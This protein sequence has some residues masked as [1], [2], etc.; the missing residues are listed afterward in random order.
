MLY[1]IIDDNDEKS[2]YF[3]NTKCIEFGCGCNYYVLKAD[4]PYLKVTTNSGYFNDAIIFND[5]ICI[6]LY[7]DGLR[8]VNL[9]DFSIKNL[10]IDGYFG[11]FYINNDELYVLGCCNVTALDKDINIKWKSPNIAVDG[12]LFNDVINDIMHIQC[13]MDPPGGWVERQIDLRTGSVVR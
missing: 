6:G 7:T 1:K 10:D 2:I 5:Y 3:E 13:E 11:Y 9:N 4:E 12:I 8:I